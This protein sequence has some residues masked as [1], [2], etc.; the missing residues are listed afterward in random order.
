M[1]RVLALTIGL[2]ACAP[3]SPLA[4][5]PPGACAI[6]RISIHLLYKQPT[7]ERIARARRQ[8]GANTTR[9]LHPGQIVTLEYRADRLNV[10]LNDQGTIDGF[11][12][13]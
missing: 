11:T 5:R 7:P 2:A 12:C 3:T 1:K 8:S 9:I 6:T 4:D 10:N 13:G